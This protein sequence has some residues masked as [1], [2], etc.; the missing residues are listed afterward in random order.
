MATQYAQSR[1][2]ILLREGNGNTYVSSAMSQKRNSGLLND[3]RSS[4][5]S[6]IAL[7]IGRILQAHNIPPSMPDPMVIVRD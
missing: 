2:W 3:A 5:S 7:T 1:P 4:V 6:V